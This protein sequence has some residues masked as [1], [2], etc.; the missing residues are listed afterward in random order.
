VV[1]AARDE[2]PPDVSAELGTNRDVL[3]VRLR[4]RHASRRGA[5]LIERRVNPPRSTVDHRRE[6]V[7]V[8]RLQLR[9][10]TELEQLLHDRMD[11]A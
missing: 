4:R 7:D 11:G 2:G 10:L 6:R 9:Q 3:E 1:G 8:R 5:D